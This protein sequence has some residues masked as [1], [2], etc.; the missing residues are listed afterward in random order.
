MDIVIIEEKVSEL[1]I[2]DADSDVLLKVKSTADSRR[3][4]KVKGTCAEI[5]AGF[6][7][8]V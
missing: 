4:Y 3:I 5:S 1:A 2:C 6:S 8:L 7:C